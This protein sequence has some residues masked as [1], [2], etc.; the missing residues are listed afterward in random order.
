MCR[1][2]APSCD[3]CDADEDPAGGVPFVPAADGGAADAAGERPAPLACFEN[4]GDGC[5]GAEVAPV[6]GACP[7][8][9]VPAYECSTLGIACSACDEP[10]DCT[11]TTKT[12]CGVCG[13][14]TLGDVIAIPVE[15]LDAY[16]TDVC[17]EPVACPD[18]ASIANPSLI[19]TC[20]AGACRALDVRTLDLSRCEADS[21]CIARSASCCACD[22]RYGRI[23]IRAD[24]E[25]EYAALVCP[26]SDYDCAGCEPGLLPAQEV[27]CADDGHCRLGF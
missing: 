9:S 8:G 20:E 26:S 18:C 14:P 17:A 19:A 21:D 24:K 10:P 16:R 27:Y 22:D 7:D 23:A 12:C 3:R 13:E 4:L 11:I 15:R 25:A 6:C 2:F 1:S 5:C